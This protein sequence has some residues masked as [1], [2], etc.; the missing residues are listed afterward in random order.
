MAK[1]ITAYSC[2]YKCGRNVL[3]SKSRMEEHEKRCFY[4]KDTKS[5]ATCA[6]FERHT[7]NNGMKDCDCPNFYQEWLHVECLSEHD[8][9]ISDSSLKTNCEFY[10]EKK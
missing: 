7:D 1:K 9:D 8:I 3:T 5:C 4:N 2:E 10:I 6:N